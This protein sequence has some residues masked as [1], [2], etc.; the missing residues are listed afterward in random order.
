MARPRGDS[1]VTLSVVDRLIDDDPRTSTE[2]P[3][4]RAQSV[5]MLKNA[6]RRDLEWLLNTRRIA[7]EP[8][9]S[10][11]EVS[12][13]LYAYGLPDFT[14][15]SLNNPKDQ[16][17]LLRFLQ[18]TIKTFEPRLASVRIIP[19]EDTTTGSRT[20]RFRIEGLLLMDPAPENISFDTVLQLTTGVYQVKGDSDAG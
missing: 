5:R 7:E 8:D 6:V 12:R 11:Q 2:T 15:Y 20:L 17:K 19:I 16:T 1:S 9:E 10:L 4:T 13:S 18:S 3:L 14:H